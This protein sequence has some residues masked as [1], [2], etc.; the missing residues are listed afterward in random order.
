MRK[1][2][3]HINQHIIKYNKDHGT[4]HP[5]ITV[6]SGKKNRYA[7]EVEIEGP[8]KVIYSPEDPLSCGARVWIETE[9]KINLIGETTYSEITA[10]IR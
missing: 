9:S 1:V 5:T 8:S 6:K 3:I 2:I 10:K 4:A 7:Q